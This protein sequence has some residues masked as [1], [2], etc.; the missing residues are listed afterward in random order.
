[1]IV[2]NLIAT[3]LEVSARERDEIFRDVYQDEEEEGDQEEVTKT[4]KKEED[5]KSKA[6]KVTTK[7]TT[8]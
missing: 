6:K 5:E 7:I 8:N 3:E 1:L 2:S 4:L